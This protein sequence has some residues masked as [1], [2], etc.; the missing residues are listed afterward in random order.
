ME[1]QHRKIAGYRDFDQTDL[2][3]INKIKEIG[4]ETL[5]T[6]CNEVEQRVVSCSDNPSESL[7]WLNQGEQ[8]LREGIMFLVRAVANP[9]GF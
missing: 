5:A 3:L 4:N 8:A 9:K 1:N 6:L 7:H 2:D